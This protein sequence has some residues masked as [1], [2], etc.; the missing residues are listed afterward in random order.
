MKYD[1]KLYENIYALEEAQRNAEYFENDSRDL[2]LALAKVQLV[3]DAKT[4]T[5]INQALFHT[6][7]NGKKR[8]CVRMHDSKKYALLQKQKWLTRFVIDAV[9]L[10]A[11]SNLK[12]L[13]KEEL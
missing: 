12:N 13:I 5:Q 8:E 7:W 6:T 9:I 2:L 3:A 11:D 10:G 1:K 4:M